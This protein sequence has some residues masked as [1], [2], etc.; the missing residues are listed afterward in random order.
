[1]G[2]DQ[3]PQSWLMTRRRRRAGGKTLRTSCR[4][5]SSRM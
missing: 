1:V 4:G 3:D 5:R 2:K